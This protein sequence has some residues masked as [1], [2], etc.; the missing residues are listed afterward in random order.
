M[1]AMAAITWVTMSVQ[2]VGATLITY[3][4]M[5]MSVPMLVNRFGPLR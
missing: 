5:V 2:L 1:V 4:S 3:M